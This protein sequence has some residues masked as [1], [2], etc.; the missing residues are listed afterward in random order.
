MRYLDFALTASA[1]EDGQVEQL[2]VCLDD[3]VSMGG[4]DWK[5][6][7]LAAAI[8]AAMA[9]IVRKATLAPKDEVG[10]VSFHESAKVVHF[11]VPAGSHS[12]H[13]RA[14]M[15]GMRTASGT[16]IKAGLVCAGRLL[17]ILN[18]STLLNLI[19]P[20]APPVNR[21]RRII[22]LTDGD[23]NTGPSPL[24]IAQNL[25]ARGV[26]IDC[27][28]IGG[29]PYAVK[30]PLLKAIASKYPDGVTPRYTFIGDQSQL[31][32]KFEQLANRL[33]R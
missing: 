19:A 31:I 21:M 18:G 15:C 28:G 9:L 12:D 30:E 16:N 17:G 14:A 25:H 23:H 22:L 13:L 2:V 1:R 8:D 29:D 32:A 11:P 27:I 6:S 33:T 7:R 4:T 5:P 3:S 24:P 10:I 20:K 26:N